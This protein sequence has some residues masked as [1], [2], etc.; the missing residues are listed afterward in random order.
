MELQWFQVRG[1]SKKLQL[2]GALVYVNVYIYTRDVN[3]QDSPPLLFS[4]QRWLPKQLLQKERKSGP[5]FISVA[6]VV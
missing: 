4:D 5:P 6:V 1:I 2:C 3:F